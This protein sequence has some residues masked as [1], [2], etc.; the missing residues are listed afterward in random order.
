MNDGVGQ[1]LGTGQAELDTRDLERLEAEN[2]R[3]MTLNLPV[4][5][6]FSL[7]VATAL[8]V[9]LWP[10][11]DRVNLLLWYALICLLTLVRYVGIARFR[12]AD[13]G[14]DLLRSWRLPGFHRVLL[15]S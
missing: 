14:A 7:V 12:K 6:G 15:Q 8:C 3:L 1:D 2:L 9:V 13:P 11:V 5:L 4:A 10:A